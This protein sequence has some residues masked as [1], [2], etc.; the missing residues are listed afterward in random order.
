MRKI[1]YVIND[2]EKTKKD[3]VRYL[4]EVCIH[5]SVYKNEPIWLNGRV[6]DKEK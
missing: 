3:I 4:S 1:P 5:E 2:E 6:L